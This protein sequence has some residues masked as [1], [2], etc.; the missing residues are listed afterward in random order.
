M[1]LKAF[2]VFFIIVATL[3]T[4]G[5]GVWGIRSYLL[6]SDVSHLVMGILS[7]VVSGFLVWYFFWF[8]KKLR[9][10]SYL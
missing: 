5:F 9:N 6:I 1:S 7:F 8:L 4:L 10:V 2:H 3:C